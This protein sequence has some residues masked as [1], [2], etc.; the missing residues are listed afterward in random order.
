M[1]K[2]KRLVPCVLAA[3]CGLVLLAGCGKQNPDAFITLV[4]VQDPSESIKLGMGRDDMTFDA[5]NTANVFNDTDCGM[6]RKWA[7]GN[8]F[9]NLVSVT[10]VA[11]VFRTAEGISLNSAKADIL[12]AY[13][14]ESGVTVLQNDDSKLILGKQLGGT[15]YTT[16]FRF[17]PD[18]TIK[19]ITLTNTDLYTEDEADYQ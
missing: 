9:T 10:L 6:K 11:A 1:S 13:Q 12:P 15:N 18:G 16:T 4:V 14:K 3:V 17:Y 2:K 19:T 7:N 5:P 8:D